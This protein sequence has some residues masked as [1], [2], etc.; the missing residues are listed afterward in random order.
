M[1]LMPLW[2]SNPFLAD[3]CAVDRNRRELSVGVK[4]AIPLMNIA[5]RHRWT[6]WS[7]THSSLGI[8]MQFSD[9]VLGF[10]HV[11]LP[12]RLCP[13]KSLSPVK[14]VLCFK[15]KWNWQACTDSETTAGATAACSWKSCACCTKTGLP[16]A[17]QLLAVGD[18]QNGSERG[19]HACNFLKNAAKQWKIDWKNKKQG[20][21]TK[22]WQTESQQWH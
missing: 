19:M 20:C 14:Q 2:K 21:A 8:T 9:R 7:L 1:R 11:V 15:Q 22:Q 6:L 10:L 17:K 5:S 3:K 18:R 4:N 12:L 13:E 16:C